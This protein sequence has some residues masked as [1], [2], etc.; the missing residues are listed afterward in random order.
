ML[1]QAPMGLLLLSFVLPPLALPAQAQAQ[2]KKAAPTNNAA[3]PSSKGGDQVMDD[4]D[5]MESIEVE[6][7]V[8]EALKSETSIQEAP[9]IITVVTGDQI[10]MQGFRHAADIAGMVPGYMRQR[11]YMG[12]AKTDSVRGFQGGALAH[13][14]RPR[15]DGH[16]P[17]HGG[18][19]RARAVETIQR[20]ELISGPGG[21]L[22]GA[23]SLMGVVNIVTK[24]A[25]DF[26]GVEAQLGG[27]GGRGGATTSAAT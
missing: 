9:A 2:G 12:A 1:R 19:A 17:G 3:T 26:E 20:M 21:V 23:N 25:D 27:G 5:L 16:D 11:W 10:R 7:L 6:T 4:L 24:T 22:W 8:V 13:D 14:R 18:D 15:S